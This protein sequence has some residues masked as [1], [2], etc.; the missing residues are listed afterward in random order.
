MGVSY[1]S[2]TYYADRL[3]ERGRAYLRAFFAPSPEARNGF[4]KD[5]NA[6]EKNAR[7]GRPPRP[8]RTRGPKG[9]KSK[10]ERDAEKAERAA[11]KKDREKA[12]A[13]MKMKVKERIDAVWDRNAADMTCQAG[14]DALLRTMYWM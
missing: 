3:C 12:E 13:E 6:I 11:E 7:Q 14:R 5:R 4:D 10:A 1:A 2:P 9:K 8:P